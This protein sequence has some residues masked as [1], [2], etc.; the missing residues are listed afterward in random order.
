[1]IVSSS[2]GSEESIALSA[3]AA[4]TALDCSRRRTMRSTTGSCFF[5]IVMRQI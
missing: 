3:I 4:E 5:E 1:M 2:R